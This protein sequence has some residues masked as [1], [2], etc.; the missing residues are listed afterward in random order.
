MLI[1]LVSALVSVSQK[2]GRGISPSFGINL[3]FEQLQEKTEDLID[4]LIVHCGLP[5]SSLTI[6]RCTDMYMCIDTEC[7]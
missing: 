6:T 4:L 2:E 3:I 7:N 1:S 5:Y